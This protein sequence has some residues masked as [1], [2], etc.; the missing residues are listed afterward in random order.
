MKKSILLILAGAAFLFTGIPLFAQQDV[1][2]IVHKDVA[3]TEID[4]NAF[5]R[6]YLGKNKFWEDGSP[7]VAVLLRGGPAHEAFLKEL[8]KRTASKFRSFWNRAVFT[9]KSVPLK[10]FEEEAALVRYVAETSGA[11]GYVSSETAT[12]NVKVIR[13]QQ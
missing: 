13:V 10:S 12:D 1:K 7:I 9:G 2:V 11:I 6:I 8:V 5:Q 4:Q 3:I